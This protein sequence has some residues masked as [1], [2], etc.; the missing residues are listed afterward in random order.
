LSKVAAVV[1]SREEEHDDVGAAAARKVRKPRS[2]RDKSKSRSV[3]HLEPEVKDMLLNQV[4]P[5]M[6]EY[7]GT[8]RD[9]WSLDGEDGSVFDRVGTLIM[10]HLGHEWSSSRSERMRA[11]VCPDNII[12][13]QSF[14]LF[15]K[16]RQRVHNW[17][18]SFQK[19]ACQAVDIKMKVFDGNPAAIQ[20]YVTNALQADGDAFCGLDS[21]SQVRAYDTNP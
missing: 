6:I 15:K 1:A 18:A 21:G 5:S 12:Q 3:A 10:Q 19:L 8:Q 4:V 14:L 20:L 17:Q 7:Y 11:I 16:A 9:P 2:A 13:T